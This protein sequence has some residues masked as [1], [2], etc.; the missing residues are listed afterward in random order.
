MQHTHPA[1]AG[2]QLALTFPDVPR[3]ELDQLLAQLVERAREV[4]STQERL[5]GLLRANQM[6]IGDLTLPAVLRRIVEAAREL[7]GARY[8]ALGVLTPD[9]Q[10]AELVHSGI[11]A[12]LLARIGQGSPDRG[13]P[14]RLEDPPGGSFLGIP[15]RVRGELFGN[16]YLA[17]SSRGEF[18][19]EDRELVTALASTAAVVIENARLYEAARTRQDWLR[20]SAAITRGLLSAGLTSASG[21]TEL[22]GATQPLRTIAD[23]CRE[24]ASADLVTVLLPTEDGAELRVE[25]AVGCVGAEA[26]AG[27]R[28]ALA[29]SLSGRVF[30]SG[31]PIR[32]SRAP[33][34]PAPHPL[35]PTVPDLGPVLVIPLQGSQRMHGVLTAARLRGGAGFSA[36]D[37]DMAAG[38]ANHASVA[39]EL[40]E[41]RAEQQRATMLG[42]R[43]RIA[44]DLHDH[45]IQRLFA[46]GLSMQSIAGG[47]ADGPHRERIL[48]AIEDLD[49]TISQIRTSIFQLHRGTRAGP[50]GVRVQLLEVV[51]DLAAALGFEPSVRFAGVFENVFP[52][53]VQQDLLAALREALTNIGRHADAATAT[54]AVT[55]TSARLSLTVTDDGVGIGLSTRRSGLA[56]LRR[57]AEQHGGSLTVTALEPHGTRLTWSIPAN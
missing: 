24:I 57:R 36:E 5:R 1:D 44:A 48:T 17:R 32:I 37:L 33:E 45:V 54:V 2:G 38:F 4:M 6:L 29:G 50:A 7:A 13:L 47:L 12:E 14:R 9:G 49:D 28:V 42:E 15:V 16:L 11:S 35:A 22:T 3:L 34:Q 43:E 53:A 23:S 55:A 21:A 39:I 51:T 40:A 19:V 27:Q 8:A 52:D 26:L 20:A 31:R 18:S 25:I 10:L 46:T 56:N 41:A 30:T